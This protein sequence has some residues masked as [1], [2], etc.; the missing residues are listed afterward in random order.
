MTMQFGVLLPLA[1]QGD[2]VDSKDPVEAYETVTRIA[3]TADEVDFTSVWM[4]DHLHTLPQ[5]SQEIAFE[6]WTTTAALA[7]DTRRVRIGQL[8]TLQ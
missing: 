3:Q 8:V 7:R 4:I 6:A 2:L 5:P 1:W